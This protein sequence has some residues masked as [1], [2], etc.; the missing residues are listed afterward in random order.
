MVLPVVISPYLESYHAV[1]AAPP[2]LAL[3]AYG[4]LHPNDSRR[5]AFAI[6]IVLAGW[7]LL[8]AFG[9]WK[10]RGLGVLSQMTL[11]FLALAVARIDMQKLA[12]RAKAQHEAGPA[13]A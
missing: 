1:V 3:L 12:R 7:G 5:L 8:Y 9:K 6:F 2:I 13:F 4:V 10:L 11:V